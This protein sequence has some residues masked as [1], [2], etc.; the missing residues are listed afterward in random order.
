MLNIKLEEAEAQDYENMLRACARRGIKTSY[1]ANHIAM[2]GTLRKEGSKDDQ[3]LFG[4]VF[5]YVDID[6]TKNWLK[7][8]DAVEE[9]EEVVDE[10]ITVGEV[11]D[12]A[13]VDRVK[14]PDDLKSEFR[15]FRYV[16]FP[17]QHRLAFDA[18]EISPSRAAKIIEGILSHKAVVQKWGESTV[19]IEQS[20]DTLTRILK[21]KKLRVLELEI[22]LPNGDDI[23]ELE[24]EVKERMRKQRAKKL[25]ER[26]DAGRSGS[27]KPD[28]ETVKM[29][30]VALSNGAVSADGYNEQ[31][32]AIHESSLKHPRVDVSS[33]NPSEVADDAAFLD[34][35]G[36][37]LDQVVKDK[38]K[39]S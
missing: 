2:F 8:A 39:R 16:F 17:G 21:M 9:D 5:R 18:R 6:K 38:P 28:E 12:Q 4:R 22:S 24:T 1:S 31:G 34:G 7:L 14:L 33:Y 37:M 15:E 3:V 13:D 29:A 10:E 26:L 20:K 25:Q 27:L 23:T 19:V 30:R 36:K 32:N 35:A 11:A